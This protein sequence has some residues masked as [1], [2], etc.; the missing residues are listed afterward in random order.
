MMIF[1][2][3]DRAGEVVVTMKVI[4]SIN[5]LQVVILGVVWFGF[6]CHFV[7][8]VIISANFSRILATNY[9]RNT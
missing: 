9:F 8:F 6:L 7:N 1:G 5:C 3:A 4:E 2:H